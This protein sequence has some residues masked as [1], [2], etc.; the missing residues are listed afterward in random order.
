MGE[1]AQ[2]LPP[3]LRP[4]GLCPA[5]PPSSMSVPKTPFG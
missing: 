1:A 5:A 4:V 3:A 2:T